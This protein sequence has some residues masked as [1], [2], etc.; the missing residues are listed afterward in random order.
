MRAVD[1]V[2]VG[3]RPIAALE[4]S[5]V[6]PGTVLLKPTAPLVGTMEAPDVRSKPVLLR[7]TAPLVGTAEA[8]DVRSD[9]VLSNAGIG[10]P[11]DPNKEVGVTKGTLTGMVGKLMLK[12][13]S[14]G[15]TEALALVAV[16]ELDPATTTG[17]DAVTESEAGADVVTAPDAADSDG[18]TKPGTELEGAADADTK[19]DS[20][21][22]IEP[23]T[24]ADPDTVEAAAGAEPDTVAEPDEMADSEAI[25]EPETVV[26][27]A[28]AV[29]VG[30]TT[31]SEAVTE[32]DAVETGTVAEP[33][34][35]A[36]DGTSAEVVPD[37]RLDRIPTRPD[38]PGVVVEAASWDA[39]M[40]ALEEAASVV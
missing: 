3:P 28:K 2:A 6:A 39:E 12:L 27:P 16:T 29:E 20:V 4:A 25:T 8:T 23:E 10:I 38:A 1:V 22:G 11:D 19:A 34:A 40:M 17:A 13:R 7:L 15:S 33:D 36:D 31:D 32:P 26:E 14:A 24:V 37:N 18:M 30:A 21:A 35:V 5:E 9:A